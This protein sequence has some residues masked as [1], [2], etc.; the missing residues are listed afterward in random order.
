MWPG[1]Q[2][3]LEARGTECRKDPHPE[4]AVMRNGGGG[5]GVLGPGSASYQV[6]ELGMATVSGRNLRP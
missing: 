2:G 5:E 6:P 4:E 1:G 3:L